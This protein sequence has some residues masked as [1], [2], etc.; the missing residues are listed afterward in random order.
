MGEGKHAE[1]DSKISANGELLLRLQ[2][3]R[4]KEYSRVSLK[5]KERGGALM[6][7]LLTEKKENDE[8]KN[9]V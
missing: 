9:P 8:E 1:G 5:L 6:H 7:A 4:G 3:K 2:K